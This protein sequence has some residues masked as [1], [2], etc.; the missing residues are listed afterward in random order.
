MG[1]QHSPKQCDILY[2]LFNIIHQPDILLDVWIVSFWKVHW[3]FLNTV[4]EITSTVLVLSKECEV[5]IM[6]M[7]SF[8]LDRV[9]KVIK[10]KTDT[11][12]YPKFI[13]F[14]DMS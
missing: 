14:A 7:Q 3:A 6:I 8:H 10:P 4:I 12:L 2:I 9:W 5:D 11:N 13:Q 1:W